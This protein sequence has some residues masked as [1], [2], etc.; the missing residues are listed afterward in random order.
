M[1]RMFIRI[2]MAELEKS[3]GPDAELFSREVVVGFNFLEF[4]A[5]SGRFLGGPVSMGTG[6]YL[7]HELLGPVERKAIFSSR[8]DLGNRLMLEVGAVRQGELL[9]HLGKLEPCAIGESNM[10]SPIKNVEDVVKDLKR[11][12]RELTDYEFRSY[13]AK[14]AGNLRSRVNASYAAKVLYTLYRY[15]LQWPKVF[16]RFKPATSNR[17]NLEL[18]DACPLVWHDDTPQEGVAIYSDLKL[19]LTH[20]MSARE[21]RTLVPIMKRVSARYAVS[22]FPSTAVLALYVWNPDMEDGLLSQADM[23]LALPLGTRVLPERL[24]KSVYVG[25]VLREAEH[26]VVGKQ[27]LND[28]LARDEA[29]VPKMPNWSQEAF[30]AIFSAIHVR[31]LQGFRSAIRHITGHNFTDDEFE[32]ANEWHRCLNWI[33]K[34]PLD[35][36]PR[37]NH[38]EAVAALLTCLGDDAQR[39]RSKA[40]WYGKETS[41]D[42]PVY[43]LEAIRSYEDLYKIPEHYLEYWFRRYTLSLARLVGR[44][45]VWHQ[46]NRLEQSECARVIQVFKTHAFRNAV[47]IVGAYFDEVP[48]IGFPRISR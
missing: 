43:Y 35:P 26:R 30:E 36:D 18:R 15:R 46:Y 4:R 12:I 25:L 38:Y 47:E 20:G 2:L 27:H 14:R 10:G 16:N 17:A 31:D 29:K 44:E 11:L 45:D 34:S 3:H 28:F 24:D 33:V 19:S 42:R 6:E 7:V 21:V 5:L 1:K 32:R 37:Y 9:S 22:S 23:E 13:T 48:E 41:S 39:V 40:Y 8:Y